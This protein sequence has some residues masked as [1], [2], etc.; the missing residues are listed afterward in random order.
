MKVELTDEDV[1][2]IV[3]ALNSLDQ[4]TGFLLNATPTLTQRTAIKQ[5]IEQIKNKLVKD[6]KS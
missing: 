1:K 2:L 6:D 4:S 5:R 3:E